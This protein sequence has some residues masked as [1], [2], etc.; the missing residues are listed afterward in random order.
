MSIW[1]QKSALIQPRT[2]VFSVKFGFQPAAV[3]FLSILRHMAEPRELGLALR[4][5]VRRAA[6]LII[7]AARLE[8]FTL[9]FGV[10]E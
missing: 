7:V 10:F 4:G 5:D 2:S 9:F 8:A 1:L 6:S 3:S